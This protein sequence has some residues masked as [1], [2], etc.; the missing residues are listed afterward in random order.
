MSIPTADICAELA[1]ASGLGIELRF[2]HHLANLSSMRLAR[3]ATGGKVP[4]E[5]IHVYSRR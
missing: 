3:N 2:Y 4:Y 5:T 1:D